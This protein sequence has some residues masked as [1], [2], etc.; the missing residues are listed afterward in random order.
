MGQAAPLPSSPPATR[1]V[2]TFTHF[3]FGRAFERAPVSRGSA[4]G[5]QAP[6]A[7]CW[8]LSARRD[9]GGSC[10]ALILSCCSRAD[11]RCSQKT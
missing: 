7:A 8:R 1:L 9:I 6:S 4:P 2:P 3:L 11:L 10:M 5:P